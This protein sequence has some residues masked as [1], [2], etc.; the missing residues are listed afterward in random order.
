MT[1]SAASSAAVT[2]EPSAL[3]R[4]RLSAWAPRIAAA[5]D[6]LSVVSASIRST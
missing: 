2:G 1:A 4:T 6:M 3:M 5:A